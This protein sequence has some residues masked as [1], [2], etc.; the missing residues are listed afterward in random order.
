MWKSG[1]AKEFL[2]KRPSAKAKQEKA[3]EDDSE[4]NGGE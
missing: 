4:A 3:M 2:C 1:E